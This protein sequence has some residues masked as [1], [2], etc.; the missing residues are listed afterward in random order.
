MSHASYLDLGDKPC[1]I[2][3]KRLIWSFCIFILSHFNF[4]KWKCKILQEFAIKSN[5]NISIKELS[6][7]QININHWL[8]KSQT[9]L[10]A[11]G[12]PSKRFSF[13]INQIK[14]LNKA[15]RQLPG[16]C[17]CAKALEHAP[18]WHSNHPESVYW[19]DS[20]QVFPAFCRLESPDVVRN[21]PLQTFS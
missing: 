11:T 14:D 12:W 8:L 5:I 6:F 4:H 9:N 16:F 13:K 19:P 15:K 7:S 18:G 17:F 10:F 3:C 20:L 21:A 1:F 2:L